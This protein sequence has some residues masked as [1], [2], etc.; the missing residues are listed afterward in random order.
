MQLISPADALFLIAESREHPMHVG[1]LALFEPPEGVGGAEFAR[2]AYERLMSADEVIHP[3][4]GKRPSRLLG[5]PQLLWAHDA[6]VDLGHHVQHWAV[7][8]PGELGGL[9]E[10][11]SGMHAGLLDR[12]RPLWQ[13]HIIEGLRDGRVALY[14]KIHHSLIDGVGAQRLLHRALTDDPHTE[15]PPLPWQLPSDPRQ[16]AHPPSVTALVRGVAQPAAAASVLRV[17]RMVLGAQQQALPFTAP[18]TVFNGP[19]AQARHCGVRSWPLARIKQIGKATD[20]TVNDVVLAVCAGALRDYLHSRDALPDTPL[21][22]MVPVSVRDH[23]DPAD[24]GNKVAAV[25]C[26]LATHLPDPADRLTTISAAMRRGKALYDGL[27]H[28]EAFAA[29]ALTLSPLALTL[30]AAAVSLTRPPFNLVISNIP[31]NREPRYWN[32]ARLDASYPLSI[33]V[34]G[35]ALNITV[36]STGGNLDFGVVACRRTVPD[37]HRLLDHLDTAL[38]TLEEGTR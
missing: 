38:T 37:L 28:R 13:M 34:H 10:L 17:A 16:P 31:G 21:I 26:Q 29:T 25:L 20:A 8:A 2:H 24:A 36:T 12:H 5:I 4:F 19:I 35:Q 33:P 6:T 3:V 27:S 14:G 32:G 9:L 23:D 11:V 1:T 7:P 22:A 18:R 30:S 15:H